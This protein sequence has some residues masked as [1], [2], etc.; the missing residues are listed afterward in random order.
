[1]LPD[2]HITNTFN[3]DPEDPEDPEDPKDPDTCKV[4]ALYRL[5]ASEEEKAAMVDNYRAGGY[6]YGNA[7]NDYDGFGQ[8]LLQVGLSKRTA[9]FARFRADDLCDDH[10]F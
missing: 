10:Q 8:R 1:M 2:Y 3:T 7:R 9:K 5:F 6:G 4:F